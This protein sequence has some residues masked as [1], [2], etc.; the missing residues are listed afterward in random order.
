MHVKL[1][2]PKEKKAVDNAGMLRYT[3]DE[4]NKF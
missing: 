2:Q 3:S 1:T 4:Q